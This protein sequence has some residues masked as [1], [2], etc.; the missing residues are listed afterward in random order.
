MGSVVDR[1]KDDY[2]QAVDELDARLKAAGEDKNAIES[3]RA[4]RAAL[5]MKYHSGP[6]VNSVAY[7]YR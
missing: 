4:E 2:R 7:L 6:L 3:I 5:E 1:I